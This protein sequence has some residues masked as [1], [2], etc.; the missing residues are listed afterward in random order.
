MNYEQQDGKISENIKL[1]IL[2]Y[3][4]TKGKRCVIIIERVAE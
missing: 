4:L 3:M 2:I 1:K